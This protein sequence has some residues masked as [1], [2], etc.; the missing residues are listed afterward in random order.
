[1]TEALCVDDS[2]KVESTTEMK[3]EAFDLAI[4]FSERYN[5]AGLD[6]K[7]EHFVLFDS[8]YDEDSN[9]HCVL[10]SVDEVINKP[11]KDIMAV[12]NGDRGG[13]VCNGITR[14]VG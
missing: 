6:E 11:L 1:M 14:I 9:E 3:L 5:I 2:C 13:I 12:I 10:V 4:N 8:K 7:E